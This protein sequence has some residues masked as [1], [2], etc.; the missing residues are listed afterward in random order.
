MTEASGRNRSRLSGL[1][2]AL[3][4]PLLDDC[5]KRLYNSID[6]EK[7]TA[8]I[9]SLLAVG[10]DSFV[11]VGTTGQSPTVTGEQHVEFVR[12][13]HSK[14]A[15]KARIIAGAGSNCTR[16]SV[17]L[18]R[19][20]HAIDASIPCLCVT[21]YY[22]NPPQEGLYDHFVTIAEDGGADI[23]LYNAPGRTASY[24][25]P[26]TILQLAT[27]PRIV[28]L[29]QSVDFMNPGRFREDILEVLAGTADLDFTILSGE[30]DGLASLL[31]MGGHGLISATSNIPEAASRFLGIL[32]AH[33]KGDTARMHALQAEIAP[34]VKA[35]FSRKS[36]IPLAAF[37]GSPL[38]QPLTPLQ[39]TAGGEQLWAELAEWIRR[40]APSLQRWWKN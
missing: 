6:F 33:A 37:F 40:D 24:L 38:F 18:I 8:M 22:N 36:P 12:F 1:H 13:V 2:V 34:F 10:V 3:F 11:P 26:E 35:V 7:A 27:H 39:A 5:P 31:E 9:D 32:A 4:T 16:E 17:E 23:V 19:E 28:G 14:V 15:G 21:G 30:D 20:I 25:E 29:K